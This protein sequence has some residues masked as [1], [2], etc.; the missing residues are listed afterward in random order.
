[1]P[2]G[3]VL[4]EDRYRDVPLDS[5]LQY[6]KKMAAY[7]AGRGANIKLCDWSTAVAGAVQG[8]KREHMLDFL[9][10]RGFFLR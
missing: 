1:M 10:A 2:V 8:K 6:D 5:M 4:H 3:F 7:Y 9:R